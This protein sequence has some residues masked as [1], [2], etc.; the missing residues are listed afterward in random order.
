MTDFPILR[1]LGFIVVAAALCVLVAQRVR[2]PSILA[3]MLAGLV[4]GPATGLV[5]VTEGVELIAEVGIAL[6]LFLVGLELSLSTVRDVG[7]VALVAGGGQVAATAAGGF[8]LALLLGFDGREAA[9]LAACLTFSS[10]VVAVKM[11]AQKRELSALHGRI[12]VGVLLLQDLLAVVVITLLAGLGRA[13]GVGAAQIGESVLFAFL[14]VGA[15]AAA[16]L[17]ISAYVL[18]RIL[19]GWRA[20]A[21]ASLI[22]SLTWCFLF[23]VAAERIGLSVEIGAFI[24]GVALAQL[25]QGHEV[26]RQVEPLVDFFIAIFFVTLGIHM[27]PSAMTGMVGALIAFTFF[28]LLF[29]PATLL[30]LIPRLGR[31]ERTAFFAAVTLAQVSEFSLIVATAA[32]AEGVIGE[33]LLSLIGMLALVTIGISAFAI[34]SKERLFEAVQTRGLLRPFAGSADTVDATPTHRAGHV[35][36]VGMN[37]LGRRLVHGLAERGER[38]LAIDTDPAKLAGLPAE[39]LTG[40]A[41]HVGL[42]QEADLGT[43]K[44]LVSTLQIEDA[45]HLLAFRAHEAGVPASIH[46]FDPSIIEDL[47]SLGTEHLMVSKHDGIRQV[48]AALRAAGVID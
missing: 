39:T 6:L 34:R 27:Q 44:L 10:T 2:V 3:F 38:V 28:V 48:A 30:A 14:G 12:A 16:A 36:V 13:G 46:A 22:W 21:E 35:I 33:D 5:H 24:A 32:A 41:D 45:N 40:S 23:M 15:L 25:P 19:S 43:A 8:G 9:V 26:S 11:L 47:R 17:L 29:K 37:T 1:D 18:R 31:G 7:T 4:L 20:P 42:L